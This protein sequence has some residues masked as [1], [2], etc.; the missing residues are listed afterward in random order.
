MHHHSSVHP[1]PTALPP[2]EE[3]LLLRAIEAFEDVQGPKKMQRVAGNHAPLRVGSSS[4]N[5]T[6][7][8]TIWNKPCVFYVCPKPDFKTGCRCVFFPECF[9]HLEKYSILCLQNL[10]VITPFF[11]ISSIV[12][13]ALFALHRSVA[14]DLLG[15]KFSEVLSS[16]LCFFYGE[17]NLSPWIKKCCPPGPQLATSPFFMFCLILFYVNILVDLCNSTK[18]KRVLSRSGWSSV[19]ETTFRRW[20][21]RLHSHWVARKVRFSFRKNKWKVRLFNAEKNRRFSFGSYLIHLTYYRSHIGL[22]VIFFCDFPRFHE[23]WI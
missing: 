11:A 7:L 22:R 16:K 14:C 4:N 18:K 23:G 13:S 15:R 6:R 19:P 8:S 9:L 1:N 2:S 5:S 10:I 17:P 21:S 12:F 20:R 3:A